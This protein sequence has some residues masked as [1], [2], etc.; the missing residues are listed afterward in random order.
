MHKFFLMAGA[1][2]GGLSVAI[3]AFGAHAL[4][5]V[6]EQN[7]YTEVFETGVRYQ[8]F[9]AVALCIVGILILQMPHKYLTYAGYSFIIGTVI[10]SGTLYV[11]SLTGIRWLGAITPLGGTA[12]IVGWIFLFLAVWNAK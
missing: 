1:L 2:L 4:K 8:F 10:F 7:N 9:H 11:L 3:G 6:L 12:F 5:K